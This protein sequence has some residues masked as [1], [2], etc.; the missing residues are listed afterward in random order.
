MFS[1]FIIETKLLLCLLIILFKLST[2]T[3]Y[4]YPSSYP[5]LHPY[6]YLCNIPI[7][8]TV[9]MCLFQLGDLKLLLITFFINWTFS[10]FYATFL[11]LLCISSSNSM[12]RLKTIVHIL[13]LYAIYLVVV[14]WQISK[15]DKWGHTTKMDQVL[16]SQFE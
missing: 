1:I 12:T 6:F 14:A 5:Y 3:L 4:S 10:P 13:D 8:A 16:Q 15:Q 11:L 7:P 9:R 2:C